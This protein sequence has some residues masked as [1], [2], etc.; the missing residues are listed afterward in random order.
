MSLKVYY[1]LWK[2]LLDKKNTSQHKV[3]LCFLKLSAISCGLL[4]QI[5]YLSQLQTS[6]RCVEIFLVNTVQYV[7]LCVQNYVSLCVQSLLYYYYIILYY[8]ES[9]LFKS[10]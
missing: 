8:M 9:L 10:S 6:G 4:Q 2:Q 3:D 7:S 5:E 1:E